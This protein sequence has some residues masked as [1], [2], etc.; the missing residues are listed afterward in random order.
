MKEMGVIEHA[1][2]KW[3]AHIVFAPQKD[4]TLWFCIEYFKLNAVSV[5]D[6]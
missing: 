2:T 6:A 4:G 5:G 3:T 1:H